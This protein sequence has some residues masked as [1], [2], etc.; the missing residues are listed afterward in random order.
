MGYFG[1]PGIQRRWKFTG[2]RTGSNERCE[3]PGSQPSGCGAGPGGSPA[4]T[5]AAGHRAGSELHEVTFVL[6]SEVEQSRLGP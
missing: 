2:V 6:H 1:S 5:A 3:Q 4:G